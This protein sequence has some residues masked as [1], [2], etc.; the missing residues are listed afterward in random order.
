MQELVEWTNKTLKDRFYHPLIVIGIFVVNFLAIHPFQDGN[1]RLFRAITNLL[2][3][4]A[5]YKYIPYS[6][7]ESIIEDNKE[8]YYRALRQTQM[9]LNNNPGYTPWFAGNIC[10]NNGGFDFI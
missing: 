6:S 7:M 3:L 1:G 2:L 10:E 5:G 9:T 4:K 8:A